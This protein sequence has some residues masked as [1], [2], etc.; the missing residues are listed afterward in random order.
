MPAPLSGGGHTT[1][2]HERRKPIAGGNQ[3]KDHSPLHQ[4][5]EADRAAASKG[6]E[7]PAYTDEKAA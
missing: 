3:R 2:E 5:R 4:D 7:S 1:I 6:Y